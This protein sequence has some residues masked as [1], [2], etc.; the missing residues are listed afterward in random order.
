M[1]S[2]RKFYRTVY[3]VEVL[4]DGPCSGMSLDEVL[5]E[6]TEGHCSGDLSEDPTDEVVN[7]PTMA[8]M[9][10]NQRSDPSFFGLSDNGEDFC[11]VCECN[12]VDGTCPS[13]HNSF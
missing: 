1:S 11:E 7:G 5:Y 10:L 13:C 2:K 9:L 12:M 4:S 6:I 8:K 3:H